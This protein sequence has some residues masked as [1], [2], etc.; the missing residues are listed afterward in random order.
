MPVEALL[1]IMLAMSTNTATKIA[2]AT[3]SGGLRFAAQV[4]PGL[5]LTLAAAWV[6]T[7]L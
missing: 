5:L 7:L 2:M 3:T 1:P 6:G 4:V